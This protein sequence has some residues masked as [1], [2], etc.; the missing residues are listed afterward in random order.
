MKAQLA[1]VFLYGM[2]N[3]MIKC[4]SHSHRSLPTNKPL[5]NQQLILMVL[6]VCNGWK[7]CAQPKKWAIFK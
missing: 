4:V 5:V 7:K 2:L 6:N 3:R 1:A